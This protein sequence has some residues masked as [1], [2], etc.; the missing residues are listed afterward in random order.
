MNTDRAMGAWTQVK[1]KMKEQW[2]KLTDDELDQME[3]KWEQLSGLI[4][5]R[6]GEA[7]DKVEEELNRYRDLMKDER[8]AP[9]PPP[10]TPPGSLKGSL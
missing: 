6:Y 7:K 5:Q 1:G 10:A 8:A 4:Q 9:P 3:G 2:G